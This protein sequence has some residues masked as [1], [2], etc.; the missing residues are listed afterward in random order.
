MSTKIGKYKLNDNVILISNI[1]PLIEHFVVKP[2]NFKDKASLWHRVGNDE[3]SITTLPDGQWKIIDRLK[4]LDVSTDE[5]FQRIEAFRKKIKELTKLM[6][7]PT[8]E[9]VIKFEN[10][11]IMEK[12]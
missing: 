4:N 7:E 9:N 3:I 6:N 10:L 1:D 2:Q 11:L 5:K 12:K 8:V